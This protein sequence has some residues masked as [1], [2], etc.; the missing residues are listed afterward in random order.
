MTVEANPSDITAEHSLTLACNA[1]ESNALFF[2]E[3]T[4]IKNGTGTLELFCSSCGELK[5]I[6]PILVSEEI[7][8]RCGFCGKTF[9][10]SE[11]LFDPAFVAC[12]SCANERLTPD[13]A[14]PWDEE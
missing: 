11:M 9:H 2:G 3:I 6:A 12:Q 8:V 5:G 4:G 13:P 10:K 7:T 14:D 1:C